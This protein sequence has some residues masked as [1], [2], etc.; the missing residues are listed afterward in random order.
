MIDL[1]L[2]MSLFVFASAAGFTPGPNNILLT[3][4]GANFGFRRTIPHMTG[5]AVGFVLLQLLVAFG[6]GVLFTTYPILQE[7]LKYCG[8]AYLFY[9]AWRVA[10]SGRGGRGG[11]AARPF[12]FLQA[13]GFQFMNP[14]A[15]M[16]SVSA[17]AAFTLAGDRYAYSAL[18]VVVVFLFVTVFATS[19]W[20]A[21]GTAI[22]KLLKT[23]R[24]FRIFNIFMGLLTAGSVIL[25]FQD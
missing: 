20:T 6:L 21:F 17:L 22:G 24:A 14:K 11:E 12:T 18:V 23:E 19:A 8:S 13:S 4:S 10:T 7:I 16:I 15:W 5:I 25:L 3:A 9:F 1:Q 2:L